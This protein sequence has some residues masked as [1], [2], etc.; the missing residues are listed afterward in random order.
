MYDKS[1]PATHFSD[2]VPIIKQHTTGL[3]DLNVQHAM[4]G[5]EGS[6]KE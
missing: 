2:H 6:S 1:H 5:A 3:S 4:L